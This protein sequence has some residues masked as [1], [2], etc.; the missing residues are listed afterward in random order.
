[1]T[2]Y[3]IY[4]ITNLINDKKYIG[5]TSRDPNRRYKEHTSGWKMS[6]QEPSLISLAVDKYGKD[7]FRMEILYQS[8]DYEHSRQ[9]ET[10][11]ITENNSLSYTLG[12]WGY[13]IDLGGKGH[14][15]SKETVDKWKEKMDGRPKSEEHKKNMSKS[16]RG[17]NNPMYGKTNEDHPNFG[18]KL[19]DQEKKNISDGIK[20][21]KE[22][23]L[24]RSDT[25]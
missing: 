3:S 22:L 5:W 21:A 9:I 11:F 20:R 6:L 1:M 23:K 10:T 15:R 12:G 19:S 25:Q 7:N 13:N 8:I 17:K 2:T 14:K 24:L 16:K 18:K 4:R